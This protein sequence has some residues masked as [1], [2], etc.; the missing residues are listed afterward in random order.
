MAAPALVEPVKL[1]A[2]ALWSDAGALAAACAAMSERWGNIDFT[3]PD[4]PFNVTDYYAGEMGL[5][6]QRR[7]VFFEAL[8]PPDALP[9]AKLCCNQ[10]ESLL[11]GP[12]GRRVNLDVGYL[13]H[14]K[15]VLA[16]VKAAGQKIYL[17]QG[18]YAD[19]VGRYATGRYQP[20]AWTFP[21]FKDGRYDAE[22]AAMRRRYLQQLRDWRTGVASRS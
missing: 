7:L 11:A 10:I 8:T 5:S 1:F 21:D 9:E 12:A 20:F 14:N 15:V 13:D 22:L 17:G 3:G 2:A 18:I 6:L 4:H 16:S 19:L